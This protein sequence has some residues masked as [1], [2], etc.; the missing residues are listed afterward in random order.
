MIYYYNSFITRQKK[1]VKKELE[2]SK[3]NMYIKIGKDLDINESESEFIGIAYFSLGYG[4]F[5]RYLLKFLKL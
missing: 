4:S 5:L 2:E 1:R 3:I